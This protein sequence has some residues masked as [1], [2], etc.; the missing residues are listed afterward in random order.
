[1]KY[2]HITHLEQLRLAGKL[3]QAQLYQQINATAIERERR[4]QAAELSPPRPNRPATPVL[5]QLAQRRGA[6]AM[7]FTRN[8]MR[9]IHAERAAVEAWELGVLPPD[10]A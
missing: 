3:V 4:E 10:A 8:N 5:D 7:I 9:A 2:P 6:D 1:M